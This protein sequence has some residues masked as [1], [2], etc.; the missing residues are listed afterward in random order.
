[1]VD[2]NVKIWY[3][4]WEFWDKVGA[5]NL[6]A[7][8]E[9]FKNN[10]RTHLGLRFWNVFMV[11]PSLMQHNRKRK[12]HPKVSKGSLQPLFD[13]SMG[14]KKFEYFEKSG[15]YQKN[16]ALFLT[17]EIKCRHILDHNLIILVQ[18]QAIKQITVQLF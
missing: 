18:F 6:R 12:P 3:I 4:L 14:W 8:S 17:F 2:L 15:E 9:K 1:M 11:V 10:Y 13:T 7:E 5:L 16:V